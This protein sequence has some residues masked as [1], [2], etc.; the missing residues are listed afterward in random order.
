MSSVQMLVWTEKCCCYLGQASKTKICRNL[1]N[2]N[3]ILFDYQ[4]ITTIIKCM[5]FVD[6]IRSLC[7]CTGKFA[8]KIWLSFTEIFHTHMPFIGELCLQV[9]I[10]V[11]WWSDIVQHYAG[12]FHNISLKTMHL[13][14]TSVFG[15]IF[16]LVAFP[17]MTLML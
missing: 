4:T 14:Q 11:I 15:W 5:G 7:T 16:C 17:I 3:Q 10:S 9:H 8:I 2:I 6:R 12:N 13:L 1:F